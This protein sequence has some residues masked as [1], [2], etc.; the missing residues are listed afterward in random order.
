MA[1]R[2]PRMQQ[3]DAEVQPLATN[4][5][6]VTVIGEIDEAGSIYDASFVPLADYTGAATNYRKYEIINKGQ[7]GNGAVVLA[8]LDLAAATS[9]SDFD[10]KPFVLTS[11]LADRNVVAG[12]QIVL[13]STSPGTGL[14]DPGGKVKVTIQRTAS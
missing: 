4:V 1:E 5:D 6:G 3:L 2:A 8:T 12:D 7:D 11:T 13:N 10:E 9:M 14:A